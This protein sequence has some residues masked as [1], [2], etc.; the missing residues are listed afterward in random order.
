MA[1]E[2]TRDA[3]DLY[4]F[5]VETVTGALH[6]HV[7]TAVGSGSDSALPV[8]KMLYKLP[9][10]AVADMPHPVCS[11]YTLCFQSLH[12]LGAAFLCMGVATA[13]S[14]PAVLVAALSR[15]DGF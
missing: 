6:E 4:F 3:E 9:F 14:G 7:T 11:K 13:V 5:Q 12:T 1:G 2:T 15:T 8:C 10:H